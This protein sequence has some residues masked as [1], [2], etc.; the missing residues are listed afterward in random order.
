MQIYPERKPL[1]RF[2]WQTEEEYRR[3]MATDPTEQGR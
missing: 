2:F 3:Y 1:E